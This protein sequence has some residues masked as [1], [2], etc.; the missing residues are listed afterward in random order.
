MAETVDILIEKGAI[1]TLDPERRILTDGAIAIRGD[2][3]AAIGKT[4][5]IKK[6]FEGR[7]TID[8]A[9]RLVMPGL[10]DGHSHL[11]E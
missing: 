5:E 11:I 4:A 6:D 10:V 8:A 2:R 7:K 3:I 9:S 1:L